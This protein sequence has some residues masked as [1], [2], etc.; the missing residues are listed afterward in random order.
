MKIITIF[1][2]LITSL[3]ADCNIKVPTE[4]TANVKTVAMKGWSTA[5]EP[6]KK[7]FKNDGDRFIKSFL[8]YSTTPYTKDDSFDSITKINLTSTDNYMGL[9]YAKYLENQEKTKEALNIYKSI[10]SG[11]K[12]SDSKDVQMIGLIYAITIEKI[13]TDS[14]ITSIHQNI[15]DEEE[16]SELKVFLKNH[17]LLDV[18][19]FLKAQKSEIKY[20][21]KTCERD[22]V[23]SYDHAK[24]IKES[25]NGIYDDETINKLGLRSEKMFQKI[26]DKAVEKRVA[27]DKKFNKIVTAE[28]HKK[29]DTNIAHEEKEFYKWVEELK[30]KPPK[31]LE[32]LKED[33]NN[34]INIISSTLFYVSTPNL[35]QMKLYL[36]S[37]IEANN[38]LLE[39]LNNKTSTTIVEPI[40]HP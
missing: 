32:K 14:L 39:L 9:A 4:V 34:Y 7:F 6:L 31:E 28:E 23:A 29:F 18:S 33:S 20:F 8:N 10:L 19:P 36:L 21:Q 40:K 37:N 11:I 2:L 38:M 25:S 26:C 5:K 24:C 27:F 13:V 17:L 16:L 15:Y 30:Q 12:Q 22:L 3:L 35:T 1:I